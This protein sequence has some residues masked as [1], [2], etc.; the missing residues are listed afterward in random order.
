MDYELTKQTQYGHKDL[1]KLL[2]TQAGK[3]IEHALGIEHVPEE[4]RGLMKHPLVNG[5]VRKAFKGVIVQCLAAHYQDLESRQELV[6]EEIARNTRS[7]YG[8][9]IRVVQAALQLTSYRHRDIELELDTLASRI[10][11]PLY[12]ACVQVVRQEVSNYRE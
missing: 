2:Q 8:T 1:I 11:P 3:I 12:L 4:A 9:R 5:F 7:R 10:T 6:L